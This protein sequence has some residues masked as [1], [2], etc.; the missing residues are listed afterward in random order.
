MMVSFE[1]AGGPN[2]VGVSGEGWR[3]QS[4]DFITLLTCSRS[5][6]LLEQV[7]QLIQHEEVQYA[8]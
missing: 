5:E 6:F 3:A 7:G 4:S 1:Q 8:T 2:N